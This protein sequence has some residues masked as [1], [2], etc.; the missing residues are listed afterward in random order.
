MVEAWQCSSLLT[1]H[2]AGRSAGCERYRIESNTSVG[3]S[4]ISKRYCRRFEEA[5]FDEFRAESDM[6]MNKR[7]VAEK[8]KKGPFVGDSGMTGD[9]APVRNRSFFMSFNAASLEYRGGYG[10]SGSKGDTGESIGK[11]VET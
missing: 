9:E 8:L 2:S 6:Y 7:G 11:Y 3:R 4:V 1:L 10:A 5:P